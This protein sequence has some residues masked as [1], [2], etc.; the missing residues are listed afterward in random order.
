MPTLTITTNA[1]QAQ[2]IAT[3]FGRLKNRKEPDRTK[4]DATAAEVKADVIDFIRQVVINFEQGE[5]MEAA[6]SGVPDID[7]T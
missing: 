4:R 1:T 2:R 6:A 5:A 3:A 7:P